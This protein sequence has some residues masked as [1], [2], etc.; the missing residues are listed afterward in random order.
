[1]TCSIEQG[2]GKWMRWLLT[3]SLVGGWTAAAKD[4]LARYIQLRRGH[5]TGDAK[6]KRWPVNR[7]RYVINGPLMIKFWD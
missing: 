1:M 2:A 3:N 4:R 6:T 5:D 7:E